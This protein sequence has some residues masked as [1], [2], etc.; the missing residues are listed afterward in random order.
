MANTK[1]KT[2]A[3]YIVS[4]NMNGME[5][6]MLHL[7]APKKKRNILFIY[8]HH[9]SL[10]RW[11]GLVQE[12][13]KYGTVT[14]PDLPGFGGMD[15]FYKIGQQPTLDNYADYLAAFIK[16]RYKN[17]KVTIVGLSFGFLVAT[18]MLQRYPELEKRVDML[19]SV[20]GFMHKDEFT[21]GKPRYWFYR[22]MPGIFRHRIPAFVFRNVFISSP[23]IRTFYAYTH[24][25]KHKF[26]GIKPEQKKELMDFE[27]YLWHC[28]EVR[29][30]MS[31]SKEMLTVNNCK[32]PV[33]LPVWHIAVPADN[34]F[35]NDKVERDMRIVF[36]DFHKATARIKNHAPT[37][38]ASAKEVAPFIPKKIRDALRQT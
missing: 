24:N 2:P 23:V 12:L 7:E 27:V 31:T 28:N 6:R 8:G 36:T 37:V 16:L 19:V 4:L 15:T 3:D 33:N 38:I 18:R 30:Y 20:V 29:T 10:E 11:W 17:K 35:D 34:Y 22:T 25:A 5:G 14:M 26:R 9:S 32:V 21:F 1:V 13:H